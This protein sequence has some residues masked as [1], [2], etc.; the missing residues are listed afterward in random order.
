MYN[1][2][3][4]FKSFLKSRLLYIDYFLILMN[5]GSDYVFTG[6]FL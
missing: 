4:D 2:K 3:G 5:E 6:Y 1:R